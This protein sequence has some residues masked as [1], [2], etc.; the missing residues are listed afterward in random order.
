MRMLIRVLAAT[1]MLVLAALPAFAQYPAKPVRIIVPFPAGTPFDL[2]TR[3]IAQPL[4]HS[5]GQ[6]VVVENR[7]GAEGVVAG[8]AVAK[9]PPDGYT[10]FLASSSLQATP[11]LRKNPPF[12][13]LADFTPITAIGSFSFFLFTNASVPANSLSELIDYARAR[14]G[15]LN[16]AATNPTSRLA[17]V[18]LTSMANLVMEYVP[19]KGDVLAFGDLMNGRVQMIIGPPMIW[20]PQVKAGKVRAL[21]TLLGR[22]SPLL[23]DVPTMAESG[24]PSISFVPRASL[25]GPAGLPRDIVDRLNREVRAIL[26]RQDIREQLDKL[27]FDAGGSTA[28]ELAAYIREQVEV[29]R[30]TARKAGIEPE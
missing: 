20:L 7:A 30:S 6:S 5:L 10:L 1:E 22:R 24:L 29:W 27:A 2:A 21:V 26:A 14:P 28:E 18:Q 3:A 15:K 19:Y 17:F 8:A 4:A 16:Y 23:P 11:A 12:D 9:S 13:P 25:F